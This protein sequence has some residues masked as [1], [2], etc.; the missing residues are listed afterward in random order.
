LAISV[1]LFSSSDSLAELLWAR[2][3]QGLASGI[4]LSAVS[5]TIADLEAVRMP[6]SAAVWNSAA[7]LFGLAVGAFVAGEALSISEDAVWAVFGGLGIAFA[8]LAILVWIAPE[9]S[10]L[11]PGWA[12]SLRPVLAVPR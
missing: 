12:G 11:R 3:L 8:V 6:G 5:A 4:L 2:S 10:S 7:P 1:A 9:T